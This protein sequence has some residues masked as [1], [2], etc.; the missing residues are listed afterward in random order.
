MPLPKLKFIAIG[1]GLKQNILYK[2]KS[3]NPLSIFFHKKMPMFLIC[4][5]NQ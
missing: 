4:C 2:G 5:C 3:W 1:I